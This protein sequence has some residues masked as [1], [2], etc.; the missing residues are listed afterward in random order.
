MC[1][2][3]GKHMQCYLLFRYN[4]TLAM[5]SPRF[6]VTLSQFG[7]NHVPIAHAKYAVTANTKTALLY[8]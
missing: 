8:W 1:G 3:P 4:L 2:T 7:L 6:G 5:Q